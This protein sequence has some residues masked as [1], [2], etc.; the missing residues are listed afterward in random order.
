MRVLEQ[1]TYQHLERTG[2]TIFDKIQH[3]FWLNK[4][5]VYIQIL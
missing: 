1:A 2:T 5:Y 4:L 3:V